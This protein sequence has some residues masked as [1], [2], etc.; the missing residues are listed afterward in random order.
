MRTWSPTHRGG[1]RRV[2]SDHVSIMQI[3]RLRRASS[4]AVSV[5]CHVAW[6]WYF[7]GRTGMKSRIGW[8][9]THIAGEILVT[10]SG[11]FLY[12][13][14]ARWTASVSRSPF[15]PVLS[16]MRRFIVFTPISALQL[17]WGNATD[18]RRWCTPQSR[19]KAHV[20]VAVNSG[21]PSVASSSGVPYV[22][23]ARHRLLMSPFAPPEALETSGQLEYRS[24]ITKK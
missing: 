4:L 16:V 17:L 2:C 7:P 19:K 8:P 13:R 24:T 18:D 22:T 3:C 12:C 14:M 9:K 1:N 5:S 15:S 20:S 21:P 6:G 11:V 10:G 23:K